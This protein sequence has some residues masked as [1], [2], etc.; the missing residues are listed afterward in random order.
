MWDGHIEPAHPE[1]H[2]SSHRDG[3]A[4]RRDGKGEVKTV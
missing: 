3:K 2:S 4:F 1:R